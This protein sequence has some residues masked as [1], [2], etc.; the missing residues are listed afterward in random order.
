[1]TQPELIIKLEKY[2][3]LKKMTVTK[4]CETCG[5]SRKTYYTFISG[6]TIDSGNLLKIIN[7]IEE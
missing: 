2:L 1:M 7:E 3:H 5:F 6:K 4:F